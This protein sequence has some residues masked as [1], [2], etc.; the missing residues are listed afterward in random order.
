MEIKNLKLSTVAKGDAFEE[1]ALGIIT[2]LIE[3]DVLYLP[4]NSIRIIPKAKLFSRD[5]QKNIVFDLTIEIWPPGADRYSM[6]YIIECK[7]YKHRVPISKVEDFH[8]KIQQV[9]GVNVKAIFI[10][11]SPL[12]E[13]AYNFASSK[14][15]MVIEADVDNTRIVL[16]RKSRTEDMFKIP[17]KRESINAVFLDEG[18]IGMSKII[19]HAILKSFS[20]DV[21]SVSYNI[22]KLNKVS[23]EE[24]ANMELD[25]M[26]PDILINA[27]GI[28][29]EMVEEYLK[30]EYNIE[31][32]ELPRTAYFLGACNITER[33]I[34]IHPS[35]KNTNR[36]LFVLCHE[37]GHFLLHQKLTINQI[38][39]DSFEDSQN[40]FHIDSYP[41]NNP[42]RWIE[43][44]A[45]YFAASIILNKTS[46]L[47]RIF[48]AQNKIGLSKDVI[49]LNDDF[50]TYKVFNSI[51]TRLVD[52]FNTSKTT[53]IYRMKEQRFL[54]ER[55]STKSIGQLIQE[56]KESHFV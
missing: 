14:G 17:I 31:I 15:M 22:D 49:I 1:K 40:D 2:K 7:D 11:N 45:N 39:Y 36:H 34:A 29:V 23:I 47:A 10:S 30:T 32:Q 26:N 3:N 20:D 52:R 13:A 44:Q 55:F 41:L 5:R 48:D 53:L 6:I 38:T 9:A 54:K 12:Q 18:I 28:N 50:K 4:P 24:I 21:P 56:Y 16:Y 46:L 8:S 25:K 42:R 35:V 51:L 33:I 27:E 37:F 43:W 19:D